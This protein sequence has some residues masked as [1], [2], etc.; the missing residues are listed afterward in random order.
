[1]GAIERDK[2][3]A[4]GDAKC[5]NKLGLRAGRGGKHLNCGCRRRKANNLEAV[6]KCCGARAG[7]RLAW[8]RER[9][10]GGRSLWEKRSCELKPIQKKGTDEWEAWARSTAGNKPSG[11]AA[12]NHQ[13]GEEMTWSKLRARGLPYD[14]DADRTWG[15]R[16][17]HLFFSRRDIGYKDEKRR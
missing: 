14:E 6:G 8:G 5:A 1:M 11:L 16:G 15:G 10:M 3:E 13:V 12:G 7:D 17:R 9:G 4:E 2:V